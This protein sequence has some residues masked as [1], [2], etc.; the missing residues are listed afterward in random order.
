[1]F[2]SS[3]FLL[4]AQRILENVEK[5]SKALGIS[6]ISKIPLTESNVE[7]QQQQKPQR[8]QQQHSLKQ[9]TESPKRTKTSSIVCRT[10]KSPNNKIV[11]RTSDHNISIDSKENVDLALEINI[12]TGP[13]VQVTE[14]IA[15]ERSLIFCFLIF[16]FI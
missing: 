16:S 11:Q 6:N 13:N 14:I 9:K 1:M 10:D 5:R 7:K 12:T 15:L 3:F 4:S 2:N 8:Q